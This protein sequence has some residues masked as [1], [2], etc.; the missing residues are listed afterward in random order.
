MQKAS[1]PI[2]ALPTSSPPPVATRPLAMAPMARWRC[3]RAQMPATMQKASVPILALPTSS[4]PPVATRP[5]AIAPMARGPYIRAQMVSP[6]RATST[7]PPHAACNRA[8]GIGPDSRLG[9]QQ[10]TTGGNTTPSDGA[11]GSLAVN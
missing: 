10:P 9:H 8:E 11:N 3:I 6:R 5:L 1:D 2:L 7:E 4:P